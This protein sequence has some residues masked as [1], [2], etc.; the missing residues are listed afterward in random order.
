MPRLPVRG[1]AAVSGVVGASAAAVST[2]VAASMAVTKAGVR[3]RKQGVAG[4]WRQFA[5]APG[6]GLN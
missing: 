5:S 4:G 6:S 1:A 3:A 2:V